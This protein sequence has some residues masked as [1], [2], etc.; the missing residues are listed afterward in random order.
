MTV[1]AWKI[2]DVAITRVPEVMAELVLSEFFARG[3]PRGG[4]PA[5]RLARAAL[6]RLRR[7]DPDLD[8]RARGRHRR[9]AHPGRHLPRPAPDPGLREAGRRRRGL[10]RRARGRGLSSRDDRRRA[11]YP[12]ALRS[13]RLEHDARWR[14]HRARVPERA[15]SV[16]SRGVGAL[17]DRE[18]RRGLRVHDRPGGAA[19]HRSGLADFVEP[20][21]KLCDTVRLV[22]TAGHTPATCRWRSRRRESAR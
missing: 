2:G 4:R 10:S 22:P 13:R 20:D 7:Q 9:A 21:H 8:P 6:P 16:R 5:P 18:R 12:P 3:D 19:D 17:V 14:S 1:L 11:V 15:V